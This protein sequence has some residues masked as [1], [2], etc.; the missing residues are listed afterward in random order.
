MKQNMTRLFKNVA[1]LGGIF[2]PSMSMNYVS[3][4]LTVENMLKVEL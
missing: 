3:K 4:F 2:I 1:L